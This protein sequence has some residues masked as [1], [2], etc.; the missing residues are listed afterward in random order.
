MRAQYLQTV[1]QSVLKHRAPQV[2]NPM[3]CVPPRDQSR[4]AHHLNPQSRYRI[5][6]SRLPSGTRSEIL[7]WSHPHGRRKETIGSQEGCSSADDWW[8]IAPCSSGF[9]WGKGHRC[10]KVRLCVE[11]PHA[12]HDCDFLNSCCCWKIVIKETWQVYW[13]LFES[14]HE[15]PQEGG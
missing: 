7:L 9:R 8:R 15:G 11:R 6:P 5:D 12:R 2:F 13:D 3:R 1:S 14:G 4:H 10:H